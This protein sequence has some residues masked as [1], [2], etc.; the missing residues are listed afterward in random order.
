MIRAKER[1]NSGSTRLF[2]TYCWVR[3]R[4]ARRNPFLAV[5]RKTG[6]GLG[7]VWS[8]GT[9]HILREPEI[10]PFD[11]DSNGNDIPCDPDSSHRVHK[12]RAA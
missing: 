9:W 3:S 4:S 5:V 10:Q 7:F 2:S 12:S 6:A 8:V 1:S 11:I